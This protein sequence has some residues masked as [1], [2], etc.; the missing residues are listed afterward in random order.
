MFPEMKN[1]NPDYTDLLLER[2]LNIIFLLDGAGKFVL[3]TKKLLRETGLLNFDYIKNRGYWEVFQNILNKETYN[4]FSEAIESVIK[5]QETVV[6][7]EYIDFCESG[8]P[9]YYRIE[10]TAVSGERAESMGISTGALA[11][12]DDLT[13][14]MAEKER[15]D[16]AN[17]A[18]SEFLATI[19][20]EIRTPM[21]AILGMTEILTRTSLD[22]Q[23]KKYAE[24]IKNSSNA[25]L[26]IINDILDYSKIEAGKMD[27]VNK[28]YNLRD[29]LEELYN[30]FL[31]MFRAKNLEFY[32]SVSKNIPETVYGDSKRTEQILTNILSNGLKYTPEGHVEFYAWMSDD[33]I[34]HVSVHDTGIG[35]RP[36][37]IK[38]L[39]KPF[40]Q[41]DLRKSKNVVGTGLGL[42]ISHRLCELMNGKLWI[43]STYGTGTTVFLDI[44]C[45]PGAE[46]VIGESEKIVEFSAKDA[47][48]LVVDDIDINLTVAEAMLQI[49]DITPDLAIKGSDAV[50]MAARKRYDIIFM[51]QMMP[52][53]D[54]FETMRLIRELKPEYEN[55][56]VV[57]LTANVINN[58]EKMFLE[59]GFN[60]FLAKPIEINLLNLCLRKFLPPVLIKI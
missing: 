51:D 28:Y 12:F 25:L 23:Q 35:I 11:V 24:N 58:A 50:A 49:F 10:F 45:I 14:Y 9:K 1:A 36:E 2:S 5:T 60:G 17:K 26:A 31:P 33:S 38:K 46:G 37:D 27:I 47:K 42:S 52:E 20:H 54:G 55:I 41:L 15:A 7:N 57:A 21:N 43:E 6:L 13:D 34:M 3:C 29:M 30:T 59:N 18:K 16:V 32:F 44:P 40:E 4:K 19:S 39:F 48:V 56:P 8:F 22:Y 53:M